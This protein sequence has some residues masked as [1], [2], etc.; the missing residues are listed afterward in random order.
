M[1]GGSRV[2]DPDAWMTVEDLQERIGKLEK[3]RDE[4]RKA[5]GAQTALAEERLAQLKYLQA[6]FDNYRR[7]FEK[8]KVAIISLAEQY[9]MDELLVILDDLEQALQ[10]TGDGPGHEG[11]S[12]LH[13]KF[14]RILENHGLKRI[15]ALGRPFDPHLHMVVCREESDRDE[16]TVL[17]ECRTGYM[18][19]SRVLRPALV[20]VAEQRP[21]KEDTYGEG[22][23]YRD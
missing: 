21:A 1:Y 6:D 17:E 11:L 10:A 18:L 12:M 5:A 15:D 23:D 4:S 9:L 20:K 2:T 7:N 19:K 22:E 13:R 8:E 3:E 14:F 16:G